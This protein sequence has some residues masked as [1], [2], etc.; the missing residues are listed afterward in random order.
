[1][2]RPSLHFRTLELFCTIAEQ[3]SFSKAASV[4]HLTQSAVSQAMQHLEES[5]GAQ[6]ID[7]SKRPLVL[8]AAGKTYLSGLRGI[9]RSYER[10]GARGSQHQ[11]AAQRAD[12]G[13]DD[14]L[15]GL[16]LHAGGLGGVCSAS[17]RRST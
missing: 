2:G 7:R 14:R 8:T 5:V 11:Q 10:L 16:E 17:I 9:L 3:R 4:H 1:M 12:H 15:G 13:G 6:L